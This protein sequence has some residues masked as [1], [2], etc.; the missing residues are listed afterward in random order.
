MRLEKISKNKK[1]LSEIISYAL[2]ILIAIVIATAVFV[3]VWKLVDKP[4]PEKCPDGVSVVIRNFRCPPMAGA[5]AGTIELTLANQ[6]RFNISGFVVKGSNNPS[7]KAAISLNPNDLPAKLIKEPTL[8]DLNIL[9]TKDLGPGDEDSYKFSYSML[10][11]QSLSKISVVAIRNQ[12]E[13]WI[14]CTTSL[15]GQDVSCS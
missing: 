6:G 11:P 15:V 8:N 10:T 14:I 12:S 5:A 1:A 4:E 9:T 7:I 3:W 2:L 13:E